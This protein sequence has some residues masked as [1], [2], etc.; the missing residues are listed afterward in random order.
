VQ[1]EAAIWRNRGFWTVTERIELS[2]WRYDVHTVSHTD[3]GWHS[4]IRKEAW[5][6]FPGVTVADQ[7]GGHQPAG[8]YGSGDRQGHG[9]YGE[10]DLRV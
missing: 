10:V 1:I 2:L 5:M 4:V 9:R 8:R 7:R 6:G 3:D